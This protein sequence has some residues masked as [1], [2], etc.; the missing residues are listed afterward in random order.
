[1]GRYL[2]PVEWVA[3]VLIVIGFDTLLALV[4]AG[5]ALRCAEINSSFHRPHARATYVKWRDSTTV[6]FRFAVKMPRTITHEL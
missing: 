4:A 3:I 1:M 6:D 5:I 2:H